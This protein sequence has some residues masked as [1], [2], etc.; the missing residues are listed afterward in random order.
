MAGARP[1]RGS[2]RP[3]GL[4]PRGCG[5]LLIRQDGRWSRGRRPPLGGPRLLARPR[6]LMLPFFTDNG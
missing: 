3:Q 1:E 5:N 6:G 4:V 2:G